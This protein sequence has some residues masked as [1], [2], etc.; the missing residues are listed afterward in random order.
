M[1]K[2]RLCFSYTSDVQKVL[3]GIIPLTS[4]ILDKGI[5]LWWSPGACWIGIDVFRW[6]LG[7]FRGDAIDN[8]PGSFNLIAPNEERRVAKHT[9]GNEALI[10]F[11][12]LNAKGIGVSE[13]HINRFKLLSSPRNLRTNFE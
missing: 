11:G 1:C 5:G 3:F 8:A 6:Q 2:D 13:A 7:P 9:I 10:S 4:I 12:R